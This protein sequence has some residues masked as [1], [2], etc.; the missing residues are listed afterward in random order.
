MDRP[1]AQQW[2]ISLPP[3]EKLLTLNDRPH[4]AARNRITGQL[5]AD[6]A[7]LCRLARIPRLE[8]ATVTGI[9]HPHDLRRRDPHNWVPSFKALIDG[10]VDAKVLPDDDAA[11]LLSFTIVLGEPVRH[12]QLSLIIYRVDSEAS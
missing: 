9:L 7:N 1:V 2:S 12:G 4:W 11:H 5:R 3:G 6:A 8:C 10:V